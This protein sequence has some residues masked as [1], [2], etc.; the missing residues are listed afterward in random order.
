MN[1]KGR[2][3]EDSAEDLVSTIFGT[4]VFAFITLC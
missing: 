4:K 2:Q 1:R 3:S